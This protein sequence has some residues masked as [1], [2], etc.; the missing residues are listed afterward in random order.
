M[1]DVPR[2]P[3]VIRLRDDVAMQAIDDCID[4]ASIAR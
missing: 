2:M 1:A 4:R 3:Q